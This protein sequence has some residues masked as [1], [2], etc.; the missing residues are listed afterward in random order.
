VI[1]GRAT[2]GVGFYRRLFGEIP[3][4]CDGLPWDTVGALSDDALKRKPYGPN[5]R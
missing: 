3:K 2:L 4:E 1:T 5:W